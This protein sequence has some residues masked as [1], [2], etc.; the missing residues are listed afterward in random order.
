MG[1]THTHTK[2]TKIITKTWKHDIIIIIII[3]IIT[4]YRMFTIMYLKQTML[5]SYVMLQLFYCTFD[6][7]CQDKSFYF[8]IS[9]SLNMCAVSNV[10][11]FYSF[12][13]S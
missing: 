11:V 8:Y 10:A 4:L 6:V 7:T 2:H 5:L 13:M 3:I 1:H 9:T 12:L